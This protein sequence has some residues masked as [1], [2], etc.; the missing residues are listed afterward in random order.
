MYACVDAPSQFLHELMEDADNIFKA[1]IKKPKEM[2]FT[3][4]N[5]QEFDNASECHICNEAFTDGEK[6]VR[7]HCHIMGTFRGTTHN[8]CN[9]NYKINAHRWKLPYFFHN[10]RG[11]DGHILI[12]ALNQTHRNIRIIP[13]N[14]EK[15][16]AF[17]VDQLQFLDSFQFTMQSLD[18]LVSTID[19]EDLKYT[20]ASFPLE[21]Q[22]YLMKK[23]DFFTDISKITLDLPIITCSFLQQTS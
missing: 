9:L 17:S 5:K 18:S 13:N 7:D 4:V 2:L 14:M 3:N 21:D 12:N 20:H 19:N 22:F 11:Y 10:L 1:Y 15:Y 6:K 16:V 23:N 8:R